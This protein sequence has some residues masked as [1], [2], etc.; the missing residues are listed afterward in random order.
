MLEKKS[1][2]SE[3]ESLC[4]KVPRLRPLVLPPED[5][6]ESSRRKT[7]PSATLFTTNPMSTGMENNGYIHDA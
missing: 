4:L 7:Y 6:D 2:F 5:E 3:R 1:T